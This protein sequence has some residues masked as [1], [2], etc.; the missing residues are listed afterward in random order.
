MGAETTVA[1]LATR[2][3]SLRRERWLKRL[4]A[5][6]AAVAVAE[7][8][9]SF[10]LSA[11]DPRF[12]LGVDLFAIGVSANVIL[13]PLVGALI[14]QRRPMTK[15]AWLMILTG[16]VLGFGIFT[17][18]YGVTGLPPGPSR[19]FTVT[20]LVV[21]QLFFI[22]A[23]AMGAALLLLLFPT[24]RL[25]GPRWR[26]VVV[27]TLVGVVLYEIGSLF[28]YEI[29]PE[30]LPGLLNPVGV[31]EEWAQA[32]D[33][34][35]TVGN[36]LVG[37]A[38]LLATVSLYVRYR[39]AGPVEA[40][41]IRWVAFVGALAAIT[42]PIA[43]IQIGPLSDLA[44][45]VGVVILALMP[46]AIGIAIT[47][48]HLYDID[49]LINRALVYGSLTAI[50]AGVFTAAVGLAQRLFVSVTG[51]KS[52]AAIVL[53]TLV[54]A[55]LYAPLRKRIEAIVDRQ[56]KYDQRR[57]GAYRS[58]LRQLLSLVE[59]GRAADRLVAAAVGELGA[60]GGAIV[61]AD[62]RPTAIAGE[63]PVPEAVRLS[64]ARGHA[65]MGTLVVGPRRDR[66]PY[67][68]QSIVELQD[69]AS[70]V[71]A[72]VDAGDVERAGLHPTPGRGPA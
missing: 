66:R 10:V 17:F 42:Y 7:I 49:R 44:F 4:A 16:V 70:L 62:D 68:A 54:V 40:A 37:V 9:G 47:R 61:D 39:Q 69:L 32:I 34:V 14:V 60:T 20:A 46:I 19:P 51:E 30:K 28:R 50:L 55:T 21:S 58:E 67:D 57:F 12:S 29:D 56:F 65:S 52:D 15:V 27:L 13:F 72:A 3:A 53:T 25:L 36:T 5:A 35:T 59:P 41:Q 26:S 6:L 64:L 43:A 71:V 24:D 33:V 22:P 23:V 45:E 2:G 63:W 31:P 38:V 1:S 11:S 18:G 48:Y 8:I